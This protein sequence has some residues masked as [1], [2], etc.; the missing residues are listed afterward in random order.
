[1]KLIRT[2]LARTDLSHV[3]IDKPGFKLELA[4]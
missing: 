2:L 1:M 4:Q 3:A